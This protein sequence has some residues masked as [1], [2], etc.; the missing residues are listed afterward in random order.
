VFATDRGRTASAGATLGH[1]GLWAGNLGFLGL[2]TNKPYIV[3]R[4]GFPHAGRVSFQ[5]LR[6]GAHRPVGMAVGKVPSGYTKP[7]PYPLGKN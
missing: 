7:Y 5:G 3:V 6:R 1:L 4:A 2:E